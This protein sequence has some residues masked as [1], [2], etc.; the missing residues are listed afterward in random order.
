MRVIKSRRAGVGK[1]LFVSRVGSKLD[2]LMQNSRHALRQVLHS[3]DTNLIVT[4][5]LHGN[6][7]NQDKVVKALL[8]YEKTQE[9]AFP[10]IYHF[11]IASTVSN[12]YFP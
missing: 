6:E 8:P 10:R 7:V 3:V 1:S 12:A 2:T 11:D 9:D 5:P 4:T